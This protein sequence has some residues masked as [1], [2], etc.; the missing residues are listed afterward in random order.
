MLALASRQG[1]SGQDR[2]FVILFWQAGCGVADQEPKMETDHIGYSADQAGV[3][4]GFAFQPGVAG[5]ALSAAKQLSEV[6]H[7][8]ESGQFVWLHVNLAHSGSEK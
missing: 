5:V 1:P 7:A 3:L 6:R 8:G 2:R 4:Y